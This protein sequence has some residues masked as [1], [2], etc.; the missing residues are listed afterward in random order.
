MET[1]IFVSF[2]V[3]VVADTII[4]DDRQMYTSWSLCYISAVTITLRTLS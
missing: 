3:F 4:K 2:R 1:S